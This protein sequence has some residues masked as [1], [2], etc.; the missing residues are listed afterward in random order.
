MVPV[1]IIR[2]DVLT[3]EK[4]NEESLPI[5]ELDQTFLR[6]ASSNETLSRELKKKIR[7]NIS[8][9]PYIDSLISSFT[10]EQLIELEIFLWNEAIEFAKTTLQKKLA[11]EFI[12]SHMEPTANYHRRQMCGEPFSAC[13]ANY[14][15]HSNPICAS[16]KL[17]EQ[18][19]AI[20]KVFD[21]RSDRD[22]LHQKSLEKFLQNL[23]RKFSLFSIIVTGEDGAPIAALSDLEQTETCEQS[24]F[25]K[26]FY[27]HLERYIKNEKSNGSIYFDVP[28]QAVSQKIVHD[29]HVFILTLLSIKNH[30]LDV[31]MFLA[32]LGI[33]RI[34]SEQKS[35]DTLN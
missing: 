29:K 10:P 12:T 34:Y 35:D 17:K 27:K 21:R 5:T 19:R 33:H 2:R 11:R 16:R 24:D 3:V 1:N 14:C 9:W 4:E 7:R 13:R 20:T 22:K 28:L 30:N 18:I 25:V 26:F 32:T 6:A 15:I 23:I 8:D 31:A